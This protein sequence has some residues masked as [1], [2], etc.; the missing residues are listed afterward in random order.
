MEQR[1]AWRSD[2]ADATRHGSMVH[3]REGRGSIGTLSGAGIAKEWQGRR[4]LVPRCAVAAEGPRGGCGVRHCDMLRRHWREAR[5]GNDGRGTPPFLGVFAPRGDDP[6]AL[7]A[8]ILLWAARWQRTWRAAPTSLCRGAR[9][10]QQ[11]ESA[12]RPP[13]TTTRHRCTIRVVTTTSQVSLYF[14]LK[15]NIQLFP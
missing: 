1:P 3:G 12:T 8:G 2:S 6:T 11:V 15:L 13:S 10:L 7:K 4:Q 14:P 9:H 5:D